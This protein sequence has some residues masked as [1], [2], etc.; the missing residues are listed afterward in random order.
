MHKAKAFFFI[1]AGIFLLALSYHLGAQSAAAQAG[2]QY[3]V[4]GWGDKMF[5]VSGGTLYALWGG[6]GRAG[7]VVW[8]TN[9]PVSDSEI[10]YYDGGRIVTTSGDGWAYAGTAGWVNCGAVPG[11]PTPAQRISIGQLKAKYAR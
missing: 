7:W 4:V 5:V 2:G 6:G 11:S 3:R 8:S 1:C 9:A 10:A